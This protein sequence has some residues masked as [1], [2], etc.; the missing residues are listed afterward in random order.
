MTDGMRI[1][2]PLALPFAVTVA[3]A[4]CDDMTTT[5]GTDTTN[6]ADV[7]MSFAG[8]MGHS[9]GPGETGDMKRPGA[10]DDNPD[11]FVRPDGFID[12]LPDGGGFGGGGGDMGT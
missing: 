4:G 12:T 10:G 11:A 3:L 9:P 6:P 5:R 7:D 8:D 2:L 1:R